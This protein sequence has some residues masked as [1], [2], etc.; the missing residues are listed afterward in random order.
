MRLFSRMR[1]LLGGMLSGWV[2]RRER[3]NPEAVYEAAIQERLG[4]YRALR[5]A[6]AG[7]LYMRSKLDR[8]L[9][10][11]AQDLAWVRTQLE[12]AVDRGDD[13]AA[14]ALIVRRDALAAEVER[15][16]VEL[17]D[18]TAEADAAKRNLV[19]FQDQIVR[20]REERVRMVARLAN[21]QARLR[22]HETLRG[23]SPEADIQALDAVRDHVERLTAEVALVR[24]GGDP[25][26]ERRLGTIRD[27]EVASAARAQL[28]ELKRT[29]HAA[30]PAA[31]IP[32]VLPAA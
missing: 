20:L 18:L 31:A 26:L 17:G 15:L 7:V 24:D 6:A 14:L 12:H 5:E 8:E 28:D 1:N 23:L 19:A 13:D 22:L 4:Q 9:G 3:R 25:A 10:Q 16:G 32:S 21:A 29:R 27:A 11:R 30:L 2:G